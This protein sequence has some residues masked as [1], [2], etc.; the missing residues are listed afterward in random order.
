[1]R[2][3]VLRSKPNKEMALWREACGR[4]VE[5]YYPQVFVRPVNPRANCARPYFPGYLFV[6]ADLEQVGIS[7]LQWMPYSL[8]LICFGDEPA[9]VP[10]ALIH[11]IRGRVEEINTIGRECRDV[12]KPGETVIIRG[13]LFD[14]YQAIFDAKLLGKERV[15]VL[16]GFLQSS[17]KRVELPATSIER[18]KRN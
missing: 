16:L 12:P 15:R 18:I 5:A 11:V 9:I 8:G 6:H 10:D 17:Q 14:G 4:E 2:W 7:T 13:G 3:H 1:M